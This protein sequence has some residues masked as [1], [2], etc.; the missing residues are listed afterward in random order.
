M[1]TINADIGDIVRVVNKADDPFVI[2]WDGRNYK[3]EPGKDQ[4]VPFECATLWFGD[5]RSTNL[6]QSAV[7]DKGIRSFIPDRESEVRRLRVKYGNQGGDERYVQVHPFVEVYDVE[8]N[9]I[10][11]VLD[12]PDGETIN[13]AT[14]TVADNRDL[15]S[16]IERQQKQ[17]DFLL[18]KVGLERNEAPIEE[19][20]GDDEEET[21][22]DGF[23][24]EDGD[25]LSGNDSTD[26]DD[27]E[28]PTE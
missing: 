21:D 3:L 10:N 1:T 12:D 15:Q 2:A 13:V 19:D 24:P 25:D 6:V 18:S 23:P 17:I 7:N 5:P 16:L 11:T 22:K 8:G 20:D 28:L 27:G 4:F 26:G 9:R 14:P